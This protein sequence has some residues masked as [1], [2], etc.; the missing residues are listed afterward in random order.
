MKYDQYW[1]ESI[2]PGIANFLDNMSEKN[3]SFFKYT[4]SGDLL[5][6][7]SKWGLGN[8]IFATKLLYICGFIDNLN[9]RKKLNIYESIIKFSDINGYIHDKYISKESNLVKILKCINLYKNQLNDG[10]E[11]IMRAETRQSY[12]ALYLL[13]K[14]P[15]KIFKGIPSSYKDIDNYLNSFDWVTPWHAGSHFSHLLFFLKLNSYFFDF[16]IQSNHDLINYAT[17]WISRIQSKEDGCWYS[18]RNISL[19]EKINGAM[20][21]LTGFHAAG[22]YDIP[23][24]DKLIDTALSG[25]N[26]DEACSNFNIAYVLYCTNLTNPN[27]RRNDIE[28]FLFNRI[29]IY[30]EYYHPEFGGF[31][32]Y[33]KKS[34]TN[35]YGKIIARSQPEPDMHG[36]VMFT[37]GLAIINSVLKLGLDLNI[38]LN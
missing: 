11:N 8:S 35:Y 14:K 22:I 19:K 31:S 27:Y 13:K 33:K 9:D 3:Y 21:V 7:A 12:V 25:I 4:Y 37:L 1:V 6:S 30:K 20:K 23:Y 28:K 17:K 34:N 32:F 38:P 26:D 18:G 36:T 2:K 10:I 5:D 15:I 16:K 24:S 29:K